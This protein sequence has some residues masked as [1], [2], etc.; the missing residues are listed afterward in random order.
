[1]RRSS[2]SSMMLLKNPNI[3]LSLRRTVRDDRRTDFQFCSSVLLSGCFTKLS[4]TF[5]KMFV[6]TR[7]YKTERQFCFVILGHK[8]RKTRI[9]NFCS[10]VLFPVR[11]GLRTSDQGHH[12]VIPNPDGVSH[13]VRRLS[14]VKTTKD[15]YCT[16]FLIQLLA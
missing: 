13:I 1:M 8:E 14:S 12:P 7:G 4:V 11:M 16:G 9:S 15:S 2:G 10:E 5:V 6:G 3:Q